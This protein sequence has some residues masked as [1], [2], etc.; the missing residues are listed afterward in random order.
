MNS[1]LINKTFLIT[2]K[3]GSGGCA[4]IFEAIDTRVNK[5]LALKVEVGK[6][7]RKWL[8]NEWNIYKYILES[9]GS[10]PAF[11]PEFHDFF[12]YEGKNYLVMDLLGY[13][14]GDLFKK[15]NKKFSL[16]DVL[17]IAIKFL[18]MIECFHSL[19]LIHRDIKPHNLLIG[20]GEKANQLFLTDF[21]F[22]KKYLQNDGSHIP[23]KC[24]SHIIGT[25]RYASINNH[26]FFEQSRRDDLESFGY[27][28]IYLLKGSLPWQKIKGPKIEKIQKVKELKQ[29]VTTEDLCQEI[30]EEFSV[31]LNYCKNLSFEETP[32]Y[33]FLKNLFESLYIK[34]FGVYNHEPFL[35]Y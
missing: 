23:M 32:K 7:N 2:R 14:I 13:S 33:H 12:E 6:S 21:G 8:N 11:I 24:Y 19:K 31:Y 10:L 35:I 20:K 4:E 28:L 34:K 26:L 1:N 29:K 18:P 17:K 5:K 27:S 25:N 16:L 3:I 22:T 15:N 9:Y 30:P